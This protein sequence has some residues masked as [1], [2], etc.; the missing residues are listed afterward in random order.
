MPNYRYKAV[1]ATG[2]VFKGTTIAQDEAHVEQDLI[3][4]GLYLI[5]CKSLTESAWRQMLKGG[6]KPRTLVEFTT[7]FLRPSRS[8][9]RCCPPW[10]KMRVTCHRPRCGKFPKK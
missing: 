3:A 6:V 7:D 1:D 4:S 9:C 5:K 10:K 8:A 2:K